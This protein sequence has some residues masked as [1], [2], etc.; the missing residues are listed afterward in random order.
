MKQ[1]GLNDE[2]AKR[3][4]IANRASGV[5]KVHHGGYERKNCDRFSPKIH[6]ASVAEMDGRDQEGEHGAKV[7]GELIHADL[8]VRQG[9][10]EVIERVKRDGKNC[11][12]VGQA[13]FCGI[14]SFLKEE[15]Q[16]QRYTENEDNVEDV[17]DGKQGDL[18]GG[19]VG[20]AKQVD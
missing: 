4:D 19:L 5:A 7:K 8:S 16:K 17:P 9:H 10:S 12:Y 2:I 14:G 18:N 1:K 11:Q 20:S 15:A 13:L 3:G 6:R